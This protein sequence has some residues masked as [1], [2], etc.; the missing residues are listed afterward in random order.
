LAVDTHSATERARLLPEPI[1]RRKAR[2]LAAAGEA[3][4]QKLHYKQF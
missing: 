4:S 2:L 3:R 1:G